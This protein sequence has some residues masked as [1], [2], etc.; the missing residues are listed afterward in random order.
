[1]KWGGISDIVRIHKRPNWLSYTFVYETRNSVPV[2]VSE[3]VNLY[4]KSGAYVSW[5]MQ[6][7]VLFMKMF[8]VYFNT[9]GWKFLNDTNFQ[10]K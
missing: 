7:E 1:M 3:S 10:T 4:W 5:R 6:I 2:F 9:I 8:S